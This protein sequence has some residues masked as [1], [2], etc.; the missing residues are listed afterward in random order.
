MFR[1]HTEIILTFP[2]VNLDYSA[3]RAHQ[4]LFLAIY[5]NDFT[6]LSEEIQKFCSY[7]FSFN[8]ICH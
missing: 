6:P 1:I 7:F 8:E 5:W 4:T 3:L 2:F